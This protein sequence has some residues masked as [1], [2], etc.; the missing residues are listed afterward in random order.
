MEYHWRKFVFN[1]SLSSIE[2]SCISAF[3]RFFDIKQYIKISNIPVVSGASET[4]NGKY[5]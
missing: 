1:K 2:N 4:A 3:E 5:Y